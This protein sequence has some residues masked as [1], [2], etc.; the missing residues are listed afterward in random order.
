MTTAKKTGW[1]VVD[2]VCGME[3]DPAEAP[4]TRVVMGRTYYFCSNYCA[5]IFDPDMTGSDLVRLGAA[6]GGAGYLT[7]LS[8]V[9]WAKGV[10][11]AAL[12]WLMDV[13]L[14]R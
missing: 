12:H 3:V 10:A 8:P 4:Q 7:R 9:A 11:N 1:K 13:S 5:E 2:P 14:R 6:I